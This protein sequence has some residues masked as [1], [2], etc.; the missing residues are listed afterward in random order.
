MNKT[1]EEFDSL[2]KVDVPS[3]KFWGAQPERSSK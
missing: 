3:D 2:G 1:R